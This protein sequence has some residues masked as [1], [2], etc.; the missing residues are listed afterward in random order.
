M[1]GSFIYVE[2]REKIPE[3][4]GYTEEPN[5]SHEG[6]TTLGPDGREY[7]LI[8]HRVKTYSWLQRIYRV[9]FATGLLY[10]T[11]GLALFLM[12]TKLT[13][14]YTLREKRVTIVLLQKESTSPTPAPESA[15]DSAKAQ[16][17]AP[18]RPPA[19]A[20][21]TQPA[22]PARPPAPATKA[23]PA[24]PARQP[25]SDSTRLIHQTRARAFPKGRK[26]PARKP[27]IAPKSI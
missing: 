18:A 17:A 8:S 9:T 19:P 20:T 25:V 10:T 2:S 14:Y 1:L 4:P 7:T 6:R 13:E 27:F 23:Q 16:P 5:F 12:P 22:A 15:T 11:R 24:A 21:K 3:L 26:P